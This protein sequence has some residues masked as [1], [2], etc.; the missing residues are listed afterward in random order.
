MVRDIGD[1]LEMFGQY[2]DVVKVALT[3]DQ[4]NEH[5]PPP[6][7]TKLTDSRAGG[8]IAKYGNSSWEVDALPPVVLGELITAAFEDVLDMDEMQ[9]HM[10]REEMDKS[11]L[12]KAVEGM[13]D[14]DE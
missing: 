7:P 3:I 13:N 5:Q 1:R 11:V 6:N 4:V 10:A 9:R 12:R 8:F 2:V 14:N